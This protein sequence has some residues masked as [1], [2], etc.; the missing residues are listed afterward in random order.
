MNHRECF[1]SFGCTPTNIRWSWTALNEQ[2]NTVV[3]T[4]WADGFANGIY[5]R[6]HTASGNGYKELVR[7]IRWAQEHADGILHVI[8]A[9][10]KDRYAHPRKIE[11]CEPSNL[12]MKI[13][14]FNEATGELIAKPIDPH[15]RRQ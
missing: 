12:K 14:S 1:E 10:A 13:V 8:M 9:K 11:S 6:I 7:H 2:T 5:R 4:C 3:L 15:A